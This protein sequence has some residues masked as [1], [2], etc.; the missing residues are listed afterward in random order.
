[1]A[2][3][4]GGGGQEGCRSRTARFA[5]SGRVRRLLS[6]LLRHQPAPDSGDR[7]CDY[8][9]G[10][11]ARRQAVAPG[12]GRTG[13]MDL[14]RLLRFHR[15]RLRLGTTPVLRPRAA[16]GQRRTGAAAST[17]T[18]VDR[19]APSAS[20]ETTQ[21]AVAASTPSRVATPLDARRGTSAILDALLAVVFSPA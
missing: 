20:C 10:G 4:R 17:P 14:A 6:H 5:E 11:V 8:R 18:I 2:G 7:R 13:R 9:G 16:L 1:V 12:R 15:A 19:I 21:R 3:D